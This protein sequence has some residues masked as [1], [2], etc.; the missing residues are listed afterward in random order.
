LD[1]HEGSLS[2]VG[3]PECLPKVLQFKR[4]AKQR[5]QRTAEQHSAS[6]HQQDQASFPQAALQIVHL[7]DTK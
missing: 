4:E 2:S 5:E 7:R 1:S 3:R 6:L